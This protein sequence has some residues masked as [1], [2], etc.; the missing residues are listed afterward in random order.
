MSKTSLFV[1]FAFF[2]LDP[3]RLFLSFL[4]LGTLKEKNQKLIL[5]DLL[6]LV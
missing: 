1:S 5:G 2:G 3:V 6:Q 4:I